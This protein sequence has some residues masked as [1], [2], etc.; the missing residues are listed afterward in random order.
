M[1]A[2]I[3]QERRHVPGLQGLG[4]SPLLANEATPLAWPP[5]AEMT[6]HAP[7]LGSQ[8][9]TPSGR[10]DRIVLPRPGQHLVFEERPD[11][12]GSAVHRR[13]SRAATGGDRHHLVPARSAHRL[14]VDPVEDVGRHHSGKIDAAV[15][16]EPG[17][18]HQVER[19]GPH[20]RRREGPSLQMRQEGVRRLGALPRARQPISTVASLDCHPPRLHGTPPRIVFMAQ[21]EPERGP[22]G[23]PS[24]C[25]REPRRPW[26][27]NR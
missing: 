20:R 10:G 24:G 17:E 7:R 5:G 1:S 26:P 8:A 18:V 19:V 16:E 9:L 15:F 13:R 4:Q 12:D 23:G 11:R 6:E 22:A 25:C 2:Q 14:P 21:D 27:V 3:G